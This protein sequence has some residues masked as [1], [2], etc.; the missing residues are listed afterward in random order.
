[1]FTFILKKLAMHLIV[2]LT[3]IYQPVSLHAGTVTDQIGRTF[4]VPDN[5][6][7]VI[8]LAPSITEIIYDL[9]QEK[10]LV[11]ATQFSTYPT[12]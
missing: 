7:R 4:I 5:P 10:R 12:E 2:A 9:H 6:L 11:G 1:M 8:A 3:L